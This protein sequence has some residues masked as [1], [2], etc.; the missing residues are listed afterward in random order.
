MTIEA[1]KPNYSAATSELISKTMISPKKIML[2]VILLSI[3]SIL[4]VIGIVLKILN[5]FDDKASWGYYAATISFLL[6]TAGAAPMVAIAPTIAKADW[7]RPIT[8]I[9]SLFSVVGII[10]AFASIPL[11]FALP[12]LIIDETRRRSIWFE[13]TNFSPHVWFGIAIFG[14]ALCGLGLLNSSSIPDL[15]AM[16]DHGTRWRKKLGKSLSREDIYTERQ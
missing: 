8:R 10:T 11:I 4:G 5:G 6:T 15:A 16:R 13:A 1:K 2:L 12:P 3:F 14:L 7:V 9:A